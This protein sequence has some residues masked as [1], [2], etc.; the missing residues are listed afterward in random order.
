[1]FSTYFDATDFTQAITP[2]IRHR[3]WQHSR[4]QRSDWA[5]WN[6]YLNQIALTSCLQ[7]FKA[8]GRDVKGMDDR[9]ND[10]TWAFLNGSVITVGGVRIAL[11][12]SEAVDQSELEVPQEWIDIPSWA[13]DYY[14]AI[15]ITPDTEILHLSGYATHQQIKQQGQL[16]YRSYHLDIEALTQDLN[17]LWLTYERVAPE[18]TRGEIAAPTSLSATQS[19]N[20]V[21]RLGAATELL[22]R[23]AVPFTMWS[24]LVGD[25]QWHEQLYR[26][27]QG[28]APSIVT[29]LGQW[30]QGQFD[31]TWQPV[32]MVLAPQSIAIS[33]RS[34]AETTESWVKRV[35][36]IAF[37]NGDDLGDDLGDGSGNVGLLL[38]LL[39]IDETEVRVDLQIH[40]IGE[41]IHLPGETQLRLLNEAGLEIA[42]AKASVTETIRIQFR[43]NQGEAFQVE[44]TCHGQVV[45]ERFEF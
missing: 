36:V 39:P 9:T 25:P 14:L 18:Q 23:L 17:L 19:E 10:R 24:A 27:R 45:L 7:S 6:A 29:R 32:E 43:A 44:I 12:P 8:E 28:E 13:A 38:N 22:P 20:L 41:G 15:Y 42:Q 40:P 33:T 1:M 11:M 5:Q 34:N 30:L 21:Q 26:Q 37:N 16:D 2:E 31:Q 4:Q 35:K 3:A